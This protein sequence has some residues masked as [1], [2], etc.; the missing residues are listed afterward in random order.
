MPQFARL[1]NPFGV[2]FA[3]FP[4]RSQQRHLLHHVSSHQKVLTKFFTGICRVHMR[5]D[6][7]GGG[8][9]GQRRYT[10]WGGTTRARLDKCG[11]PPNPTP[12]RI[13]PRSGS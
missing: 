13:V 3:R 4:L 9:G 12:K 8:V 2:G 7:G 10:S 1:K 5:S 11:K 6:L